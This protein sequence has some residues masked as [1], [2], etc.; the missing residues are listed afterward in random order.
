MKRTATMG[1]ALE[2]RKVATAATVVAALAGVVTA[3]LALAQ[4]LGF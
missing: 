4:W 1:K 3:I 2:S